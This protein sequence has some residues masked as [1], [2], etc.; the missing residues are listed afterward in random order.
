MLQN[1]IRVLNVLG[2]TNLGG[3]ESRVMELYRV[4]DREKVQ[5]DFIVHN[6]NN[7]T[8]GHYSD[9]IRSLGGRIYSVPR[10]NGVNYFAY[11]EAFKAF[12]DEHNDYAAVQASVTST[13][14]I[15]LPIAK[16]AGIPM[17]IA[18]ARSAGVDKGLKGVATRLI[19]IPLKNR[20]D[21]LFTCSKEA[22]IAVYGSKAVEAG[23]VY[24]VADA[25]DVDRFKYSDR[26]RSEVRAELG[27][28]NKFVI[29]HVGRFSFMK[30]HEYLIDIFKEVCKVRD[31][32]VLVLIGKGELMEAIKEK[33]KK[34]GIGDKVY[35]LGTR[36]DVERYYQAF[37]YFVFP[38]T[39]EGIPGSVTEAQ[40]SGLKC[41]ISDRITKEVALTELVTYM[42]I[43]EPTERWACEILK[44][45]KEHSVRRNH[46]DII[47]AKGFDVK[48]QARRYEEF[49]LTGQNPPG[50]I[51]VL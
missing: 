49:Y 3:A 32:A 38:S 36:P 10:F 6:M 16:K 20:A 39:F 25:I 15:Y 21:Y 48:S 30:N 22:G 40:A 31:D 35:F 17:T 7:G 19:R 44:N 50:T 42:S 27:I 4:I 41:L 28:E 5:F 29:G 1:P 33:T 34:L 37:D 13:A 23:K 11:K 46:S 9:E 12:F 43:D 24:T 45:S 47:K 26:I 2:T 8:N 18:H 51:T 14:S